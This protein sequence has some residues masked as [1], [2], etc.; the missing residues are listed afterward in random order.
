M[1]KV[2]INDFDPA[3]F[4]FDAFTMTAPGAALLKLY[5]KAPW[6]LSLSLTSYASNAAALS[7]GLQAGDLYRLGDTI[8]IVH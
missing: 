3:I 4:P 6:I 5:L 8:G 1:A 7:A 2:S